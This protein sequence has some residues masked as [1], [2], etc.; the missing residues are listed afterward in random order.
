MRKLRAALCL[1]CLMLLIP[2]LM[3]A[4]RI[5]P[6]DTRPLVSEKYA[7]WSGVLS[8]W[9]FEGWPCGNGSIAPWLNQCVASFEKAH[10]GVYVQPQYVDA[11]AIA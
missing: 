11:G 9:I 2:A 8:L 5:L 1:S 6:L 7:G 4:H 10:P 3:Q